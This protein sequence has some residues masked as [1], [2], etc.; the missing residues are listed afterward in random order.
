M[1]FS[2]YSPGKKFQGV[3]MRRWEGTVSPGYSQLEMQD[4]V[5]RLSSTHNLQC[6]S[7]YCF[8]R[9]A[10]RQRET[11]G[12]TCVGCCM[13]QTPQLSHCLLERDSSQCLSLLQGILGDVLQLGFHMPHC[14]EVISY[15]SQTLL[16]MW[17]MLGTFL[18]PIKLPAPWIR[19][20]VLTLT[21]KVMLSDR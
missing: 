15:L 14:R 5:A 3:G 19:H 11:Q 10:S 6:H 12:G 1:Y 9:Y 17:D 18:F 20:L 2:Y 7:N 13:T 21:Y 4:D 16:D 8:C